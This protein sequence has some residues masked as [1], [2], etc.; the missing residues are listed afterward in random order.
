MSK[1]SL[2]TSTDSRPEH[3]APAASPSSGAS[4]TRSR[5][6]HIV[7]SWILL[8]GIVGALILSL[9]LGDMDPRILIAPAAALLIALSVML[10]HWTR[11]KTRPPRAGWPFLRVAWTVVFWA[12]ITGVTVLLALGGSTYA[13]SYA[14]VIV[15]Y[16][17][18]VVPLEPGMYEVLLPTMNPPLEVRVVE[19]N[20]SVGHE[21]TEHGE[22]LRIVAE[23]NVTVRA[24]HEERVN[25]EQ[26]NEY[27]PTLTTSTRD[28]PA[29]DSDKQYH[30]YSERPVTIDVRMDVGDRCGTYQNRLQTETTPGWGIYDG[31]LYHPHG[32]ICGTDLLFLPLG[33]VVS[34]GT[35]CL[36]LFIVGTLVLTG[37]ECWTRWRPGAPNML[38]GPP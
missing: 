31:S 9:W 24:R 17:A 34:L 18:R 33:L 35:L 14:Q 30:V 21:E 28:N 13:P 25:T 4:S 32:D 36:P 38:R 20:A 15:D 2:S 37:L 27:H 29:T 26:L 3:P 19:G 23:G 5:L 8:L 11:R 6:V 10:V 7:G 22:A 12:G 16:E 1:V